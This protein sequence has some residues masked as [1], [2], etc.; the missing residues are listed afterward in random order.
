M[1]NMSATRTKWRAKKY[2]AAEHGI[3]FNLSFEDYAS[4]LV[5]AGITEADVGRGAEKYCLG[6][7]GDEGPYEL[8]NCRFI[9]NRENG[10]EGTDTRKRRGD[11]MPGGEN[12]VGENHWNHQGFVVTPWGE[13]ESLRK[14]AKAVGSLWG[15][16]KIKNLIH[17]GAEGYCYR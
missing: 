13:F 7:Y 12:F 17:E 11:G 8:G 16:N 3:D 5:E 4:L 9:T 14:A 15:H 6:R 10:I 2:H 1:L